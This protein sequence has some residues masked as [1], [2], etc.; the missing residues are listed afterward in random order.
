MTF[1]IVGHCPRTGQLGVAVSTAVPA[2][3]SMCPYVKPG[4][5]A[6]STQSWV[7]PYL[8]IEALER[9]ERGEPGPAALQAVLAG[10]EA[11]DVRQIGLVDV[12]GRAASWSG[13]LCTDWFGHLVDDHFAVQ[14]NMLVGEATVSSMA[15]AYREAASRDLAERLLLAM[16]AGQAAGGDKRGRQSAS[17]IVYAEE[18]YALLDLRVDEHPDPVAELRRIHGIARLQLMPFV[19]GM[20]KKKKR[21]AVAAPAEVVRMLLEPP[22]RRPGG[23]G[24][25]P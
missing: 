21:V 22:P 23:G 14:G 13:K 15:A 12:R 9:M 24:S 18:D 5:G 6:V 10:D 3:G 11:R 16:E 7:N 8:A 19:A 20:P 1:S 4:V 2:V 25:A 17:L